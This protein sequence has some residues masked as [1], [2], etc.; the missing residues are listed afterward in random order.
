MTPK[1]I[2]PQMCKN[3]VAKSLKKEI[4][5]RPSTQYCKIL[6]NVTLPE[7]LTWILQSF[8]R[9]SIDILTQPNPWLLG[10]HG[11]KVPPHHRCWL[12]VAILGDNHTLKGYR[13]AKFEAL[14]HFAL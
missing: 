9:D 13:A 10:D 3:V 14:A 6:R 1:N 11:L 2:A 4:S 5:K 12:M 7:W 8:F